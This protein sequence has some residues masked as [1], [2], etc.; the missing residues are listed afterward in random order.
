M[1]FQ[2]ACWSTSRELGKKVLHWPAKYEC[3]S[4][5]QT[6]WNT[7]P[8]PLYKGTEIRTDPPM[9]FLICQTGCPGNNPDAWAQ[10]P[11]RPILYRDG[12]IA[13]R[14]QNPRQQR[15]MKKFWMEQQGSAGQSRCNRVWPQLP[16]LKDIWSDCSLSDDPSPEQRWDLFPRPN[17]H[18]TVCWRTFCH[19]YDGTCLGAHSH[20]QNQR[21]TCNNSFNKAI[22]TGKQLIYNLL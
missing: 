12:Q 1:D 6:G 3:G 19:H 16:L 18:A 11:L 21:H 13:D 17:H 9:S 4:S 8:F 7:R 15:V 5:W 10:Y 20:K 2:R 14:L 22:P